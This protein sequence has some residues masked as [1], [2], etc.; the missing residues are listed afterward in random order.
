MKIGQSNTIYK[1]YS[2][3]ADFKHQHLKRLVVGASW[4]RMELLDLTYLCCTHNIHERTV[5]AETG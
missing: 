2:V 1:F 5:W 3:Q 4:G